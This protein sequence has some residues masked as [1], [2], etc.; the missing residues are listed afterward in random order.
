MGAEEKE[1]LPLAKEHLTKEDWD[2][3]DAAFLG[4]ADPLVGIDA[5][6]EFRGLFRRIVNLTPPPIGLGPEP[7]VRRNG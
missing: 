3:I 6:A 5:G 7:K 1:V 4:H 2:T